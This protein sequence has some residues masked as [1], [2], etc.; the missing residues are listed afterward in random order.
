MYRAPGRLGHRPLGAG[1]KLNLVLGLVLSLCARA[2]GLTPP[3]H[4][5]ASSTD[6]ASIGLVPSSHPAGSIAN[7]ATTRLVPLTMAFEPSPVPAAGLTVRTK[8]RRGEIAPTG[9]PSR[10]ARHTL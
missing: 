10:E 9:G 2:T 5:A 6:G 4:P 8:N 1:S 7:G 3:P